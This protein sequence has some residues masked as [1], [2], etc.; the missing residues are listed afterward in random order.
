MG[1]RITLYEAALAEAEATGGV[2]A[3][4]AAITAFAKADS[5]FRL[6]HR[7]RAY[8]A[9][10]FGFVALLVVAAIVVDW[11]FHGFTRDYWDSAL[12]NAAIVRATAFFGVAFAC[13]SLWDIALLF[14]Q[15]G[16]VPGRLKAPALAP[17]HA[18]R[19]RCASTATA[20]FEHDAK[21]IDGPIFKSFWSLILFSQ[22]PAHRRFR[23][24][25]ANG[26]IE[27]QPLID[28]P[29]SGE[30]SVF[31]PG[32]EPALDAPVINAVI[33]LS[34]TTNTLNV[35]NTYHAP[36][37]PKRRAK[38]EKPHW[39]SSVS[40]E[41]HLER[42]V[43]IANHWNGSET[44]QVRTALDTAFARTREGQFPNIARGG[45]VDEI[46]AALKSA[47]L[48]VGLG[49][50]NSKEWITKMFGEGERHDYTWVRRFLTEPDFEPPYEL[51][52]S[53]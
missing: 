11:G 8:I 32:G 15:L 14:E 4:Q 30:V 9:S 3:R 1:R 25:D 28:A 39:Y 29:D 35:Q 16:I 2:T 22:F 31:D 33:N 34:S 41:M 49:K 20:A 24:P 44:D 23:L 27:A 10:A 19:E 45:L 47:N 7:V 5:M 13:Y 51:P 43:K 42:S 26:V 40:S 21:L 36:P 50:T 53:P 12:P 17:F 48:K 18:V 38:P 52:F 6:I 37:E 46:V